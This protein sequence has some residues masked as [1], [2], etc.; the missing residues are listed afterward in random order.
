MAT[1]WAG[2]Y[3]DTTKNLANRE[4][5]VF[6]WRGVGYATAH[7]RLIPCLTT[8]QRVMPE[9]ILN[10]PQ[11]QQMTGFSR[12]KIYN[13]AGKSMFPERTK[14]GMWLYWRKSQVKR[15]GRSG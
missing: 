15:L 7:G 8:K 11:T 9:V 1:G 12:S 3:I 2:P 6:N 10:L 4:K 13:L 14:V 5:L